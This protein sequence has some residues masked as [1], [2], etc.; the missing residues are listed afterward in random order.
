MRNDAVRQSSKY[1]ED[2]QNH[3]KKVFRVEESVQSS[4]TATFFRGTLTA[5]QPDSD[6]IQALQEE[7]ER[8]AQI[9]IM[10]QPTAKRQYS[11]TTD[12]SDEVNEDEDTEEQKVDVASSIQSLKTHGTKDME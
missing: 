9:Q 4:K 10:V 5:P 7:L 11:E 8:E 6:N 2:M 12:R 3:F 1:E